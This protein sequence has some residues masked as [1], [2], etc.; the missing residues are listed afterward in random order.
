MYDAANL[1]CTVK[2]INLSKNNLYKLTN[3][4]LIIQNNNYATKHKKTQKDL[5]KILDLTP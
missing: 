5:L 3:Y 4:I 1:L 2:N